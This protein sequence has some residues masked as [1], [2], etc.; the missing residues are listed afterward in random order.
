MIALISGRPPSLGS[1]GPLRKTPSVKLFPETKKVFWEI[2][3]NFP[4][5]GLCSNSFCPGATQKFPGRNSGFPR[6]KKRVSPEKFLR[7][8]PEDFPASKLLWGAPLA[9]AISLPD[10]Q[11]AA[12]GYKRT[13]CTHNPSPPSLILPRNSRNALARNAHACGSVVIRTLIIQVAISRT[14]SNAFSRLA[15]DAVCDNM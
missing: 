4:E 9:P 8:S 7:V 11:N 10:S 13:P 2:P 15:P 5:N 12:K 14:R 3:G 6:K 1:G